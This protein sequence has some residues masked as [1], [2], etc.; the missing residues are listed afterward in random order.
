MKSIYLYAVVLM[1]LFA[2][3]IASAQKDT[4]TVKKDTT[5]IS[6][7][8]TAAK[9]VIDTTAAKPK[10]DTTVMTTPTNCYKQWYD[11]FSERGAKPVPDGTHEV[12]IAFK[13]GESCHCFMGKVE[14]S[15]GKIKSPLYVQTEG[16]EYKT[17]TSLGKK[18]DP[19]FVLAQGNDLYTINN[20]MSV[21]F[22]TADQEY[23]RIFFY[24][25]L[26]K[27]KQMNKEAPSPTDLLKN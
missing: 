5:A 14:V 23:G 16:G 20:G 3:V 8:D 12:V 10:V 6:K 26:N 24:K 11:Y 18:L 25:F 22:R 9:A 7:M 4:A 17:F 27:D 1:I 13:S 15:G 2:P 19:E 21:L